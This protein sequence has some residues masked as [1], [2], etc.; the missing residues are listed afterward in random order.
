MLNVI[1]I[2]LSSPIFKIK[3]MSQK[4]ILFAHTIVYQLYNKSQQQTLTRQS[5]PVSSN[6]NHSN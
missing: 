6:A 2:F 4:R 5:I 3:I 1:S